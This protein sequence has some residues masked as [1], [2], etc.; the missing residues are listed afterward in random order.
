MIL[1]SSS[2][3][4]ALTLKKRGKFLIKTEKCFKENN[5]LDGFFE[6]SAKSGINV[7]ESFIV[8]AKKLYIKN[9]SKKE[10]EEKTSLNGPLDSLL[11]S[12]DEPE[13]DKKRRVTLSQDNAKTYN[14]KNKSKN[15]RGCC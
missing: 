4:T 9:M 3:A 12:S 5:G 1:P 13:S 14:A 10:P 15:K 6:T 11:F 8:A 7:E 2:S